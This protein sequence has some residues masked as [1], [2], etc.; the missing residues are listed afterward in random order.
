M[1]TR[2][3]NQKIQFWTLLAILGSILIG[4]LLSTLATSL[5]CVDE[6]GCLLQHCALYLFSDE[7]ETLLDVSISRNPKCC[8]NTGSAR[9][10]CIGF[11]NDAFYDSGDTCQ[12]DVN[13]YLKARLVVEAQATKDL[14]ISVNSALQYIL[15]NNVPDTNTQN[16]D[17]ATV[18]TYVL[19]LDYAD[20]DPS[21]TL[22][23]LQPGAVVV[24]EPCKASDQVA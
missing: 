10:T 23:N 2:W 6:E 15:D 12:P 18:K 7:Y 14:P 22:S 1:F 5:T 16:L 13:A 11:S 4:L 19:G 3:S 9:N 24:S 21:A 17:L 20:L 8:Y